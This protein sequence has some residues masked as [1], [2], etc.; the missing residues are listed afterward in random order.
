MPLFPSCKKRNNEK[1]SEYL[2]E[3]FYSELIKDDIEKT[4]IQEVYNSII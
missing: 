3:T 2:P 4:I 1:Q